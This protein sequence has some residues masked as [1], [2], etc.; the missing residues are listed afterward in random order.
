MARNKKPDYLNELA[1]ISEQDTRIAF[2]NL[3]FTVRKLDKEM[4]F[5]EG[6]PD[7]LFT[8]EKDRILCE[9]KTAHSAYFNNELG[10][11]SMTIRPRKYPTKAIEIRQDKSELK[12]RPLFE[13]ST[14]KRKAAIVYESSLANIPYL[15]AFF[16]DPL[17]NDF[18]SLQLI[19]SDYPEISACI[20]L[21]PDCEYREQVRKIP[22]DLLIRIIDGD[23]SNPLPA[24][25]PYKHWHFVMNPNA[26]V[27]INPNMI[28][29]CPHDQYFHEHPL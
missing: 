13:N 18:L 24:E 17:A 3:R 19:I 8:R 6:A 2:E 4:I 22:Q 16:F 21:F 27:P 11:I 20:C 15:V 25:K 23:I 5:K 7:F 29:I 26:C 14:A 12:I 9:V 1:V 10:H 28:G